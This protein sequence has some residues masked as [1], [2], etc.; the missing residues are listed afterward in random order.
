MLYEIIR[1][2]SKEEVR[3][4]KLLIGRVTTEDDRM[5]ERLFDHLRKCTSKPGT[6]ESVRH[7]YGKDTATI[8]NRLYAIRNKLFRELRKS[9]LFHHSEMDT[10]QQAFAFFLLARVYHKKGERAV[11][12]KLL[13]KAIATADKDDVFE[14]K[15]LAYREMLGF[16]AKDTELPVGELIEARS[17]NA[18]KLAFL[19]D[20]QNAMAFVM[21]SLRKSNFEQEDRSVTLILEQVLGQLKEKASIFQSPKG[22][23]RLF[24]LTSNLLLQQNAFHQLEI[25]LKQ[26]Y[27]YFLDHDFFNKN[28]HRT[29]IIMLL[30]LVNATYKNYKFEESLAYCGLFLE[31]ISAYGQQYYQQFILVH[32]N[33]LVNNYMGLGRMSDAATLLE[34]MVADKEIMGDMK[35]M[36]LLQNLAAVR[37]E[38]GAY[39]KV[40]QALSKAYIHPG[41]ETINEYSQLLMYIFELVVRFETR[42]HEYLETRMKQVRSWCRESLRLHSDKKQF[43]D[44][45]GRLTKSALVADP[46]WDD[47]A[48]DAFMRTSMPYLPGQPEIVN[49]HLWIKAKKSGAEYRD[50]V[51]EA[52]RAN[53]ELSQSKARLISSRA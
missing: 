25:Y 47:P 44:I 12:Q 22:R 9:M 29:R 33:N 27:Q 49:Y 14:V 36:Y 39:R 2:M 32:R 4:F 16:S 18:D 37:F 46:D 31:A 11:A 45:L 3:L 19:R 7:L 17:E 50:L 41:F 6:A 34:K 51:E 38:Q 48:I 21:Q 13:Q 53:T 28:T 42:D 30:W 15:E 26:E 1:A 10:E 24:N 40:L 8:R 43:L 35:G 23:I 20:S 52:V 5:T